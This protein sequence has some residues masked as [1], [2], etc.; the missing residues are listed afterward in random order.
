[1]KRTAKDFSR[2]MICEIAT[3]YANTKVQY[4]Y[5]YFCEEYQISKSVFYKLLE[6]AIVENIVGDATVE[7]MSRKAAFNSAGKAGTGGAI[8]SNVHYRN[9]LSRR[10]TYTLEKEEA[11]SWTEKYA[12]D[13]LDKKTFCMKN[14]I[15]VRLLDTTILRAVM[16]NWVTDEIF[17]MLKQKSLRRKA[18]TETLLFWKELESLRE[19]NCNS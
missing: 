12:N 3:A 2:K 6:R 14:H 15:T 11:I 7:R 13:I 10:R 18:D 4:S 5:R 17:D 9:L 8:R 1:M 19:N 16:Y